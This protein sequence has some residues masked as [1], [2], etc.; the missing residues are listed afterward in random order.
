MPEKTGDSK[1]LGEIDTK[2]DA[3]FAGDYVPT[4]LE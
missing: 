3:F 1:P 2:I 4:F